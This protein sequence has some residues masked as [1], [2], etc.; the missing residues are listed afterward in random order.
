MLDSTLNSLFS[1]SISILFLVGGL[2]LLIAELGYQMGSKKDPSLNKETAVSEI[3]SYHS[4][5]MGLLALLLGFTFSMALNHF[6]A[7]RALVL[8]EE[9]S[10]GTTWLRTSFLP[11]G[12]RNSSRK[13]LKKYL[14]LRIGEDRQGIDLKTSLLHLSSVENDLWRQAEAA[15][16]V[17]PNPMTATYVTS[18]NETFDLGATRV[19]M[20]KVHIS[21]ALWLIILVVSSFGLWASGYN[22][23]LSGR[24]IF[25]LTIGLP[26]LITLVLYLITDLNN[27]KRGL[28]RT[29]YNGMILLR[30]SM[31]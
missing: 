25:Y 21:G 30:N 29:D 3:V 6:D 28:I 7:R 20:S 15:S 19:A 4:V 13:L 5:V 31:N 11:E 10:I 8:Q 2:F 12:A 17:A 14:D 9:N 26:L 27:P 18:L 24:R 1:S 23:G 16:L 22:S